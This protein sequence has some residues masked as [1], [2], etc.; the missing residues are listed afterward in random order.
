MPFGDEIN[1]E[2][3][4]EEDGEEEDEIGNSPFFFE[5]CSVSEEDGE[6]D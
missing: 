2:E 6:E 4:E 1:V 3:E 5:F